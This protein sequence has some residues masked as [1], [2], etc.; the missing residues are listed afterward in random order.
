MKTKRII[1]I[2]EVGGDTWGMQGGFFGTLPPGLK[3]PLARTL[4]TFGR[5]RKY[6]P[7]RLEGK[8]KAHMLG[9]GLASS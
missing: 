7:A 4:H 5:N 3:I 2:A 1:D 6:E 9:F 8:A